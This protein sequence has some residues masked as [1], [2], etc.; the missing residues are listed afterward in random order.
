MRPFLSTVLFIVAGLAAAVAIGFY[1]AFLAAP[2]VQDDEQSGFDKTLVIKFSHVVAENTPK[3]LAAQKFAD[4]VKAKTNGRVSVEVF[5]NGVLYTEKD[6]VDALMRG[7]I[8]M[9]APAFA[10]IT[11][12]VSA[13]EL[14][15][16]PYAFL[17]DEAVEE[18]FA[19]EIGRILFKKLESKN[20]MGIAYWSNGFKQMT[21]NRGPLIHPEDFKGQRF[22]ILPSKVIEAQFKQLD[23]KTIV[24]PFNDVYR[25][26]ETGIADG[27]ENTISNI[28]TK[29]FYQVQQYLTISN[30]AYLGYGVLTNKKYWDKLPGDVRKILMEA[31]DETSAWANR[32]AIQMNKT[33]L[34]Q[35]RSHSNIQ[36]HVLTESERAEWMKAW[37]P[38]YKQFEK[39]I[40]RE[41][42]EQIRVLQKKYGG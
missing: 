7:D 36:L 2:P 25:G 5:P 9:I 34:E 32:N 1:P 41:L 30:H 42:I 24:I 38:L 31:M 37:D 39:S 18:A 14:F 29:R 21:S 10:N 22:R 11:E 33:Q 19:G 8:Q 6:E 23:A 3:G 12:R 40:G 15:D 35:I 20:M 28:Y 13:W 26:Y 27:G 17:T 4:L 16:L